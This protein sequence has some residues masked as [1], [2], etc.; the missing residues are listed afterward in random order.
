MPKK[1]TKKAIKAYVQKTMKG[2][3]NFT[4]ACAKGTWQII[5]HSGKFTKGTMIFLERTL[6]MIAIFMIAIST[7]ILF[8]VASFYL[9]STTFGMKESPAFQGLRDRLANIYVME[10]EDDIREIENEIY[11]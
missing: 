1:K 11:K 9:F 5:L 6:K 8:I 2:I 3:W 7:S 10:M 4:K